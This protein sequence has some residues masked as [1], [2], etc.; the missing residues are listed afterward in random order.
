MLVGIGLGISRR[1]WPVPTRGPGRYD[2]ERRLGMRPESLVGLSSSW[3]TTV[4]PGP[5][6][7]FAGGRCWVLGGPGGPR[8]GGDRHGDSDASGSA[9]MPV[10][11]I[12]TAES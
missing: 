6:R 2:Q 4:T 11:M 1:S 3:L 10:M 8:A 12:V 9:G 5:G 7:R